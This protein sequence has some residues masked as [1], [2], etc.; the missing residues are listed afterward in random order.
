M[1]F[2]KNYF[3]LFKTASIDISTENDPSCQLLTL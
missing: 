2:Y 1:C 3:V